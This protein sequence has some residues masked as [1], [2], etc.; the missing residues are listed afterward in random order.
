M[1]GIGH[2]ILMFAEAFLLAIFLYFLIRLKPWLG[3]S[4]LFV[5]LGSLQFVQVILAMSL[6][7]EVL[8]GL[9]ISPGS[10]VF[11]VGTILGVLLV[12]IVSDALSARKLIYSLLIA[13]VFLSFTTISISQHFLGEDIH[14]FVDLPR[15]V[16]YNTLE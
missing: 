5:T 1:S 6:Y 3:L 10:S 9:L 11:F 8:P 12:Y 7:I 15:E 4:P 16:F 14:L 13:N 2:L